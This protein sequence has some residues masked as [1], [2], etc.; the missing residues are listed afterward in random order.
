M[1]HLTRRSTLALLGGTLAAPWARR[2]HAA[3]EPVLNVYN[4]A[5]YIGETT[6]A[7]FSAQTGIKV[8]Y[9]VYS[10]T[11]EMQAKMLAGMTGYDVVNVA[12]SDMPRFLDAGLLLPLD[13]ARLASWGNLDP[14]VLRIFDT[15][16]PGN[17]YGA[18]YMWGSVGVAYNMALVRERLPDADLTSLDA[19]L[20]PENAEKLADCGISLLDSP[21]DIIPMTLAWLGL[22]GR[23]A[24]PADYPAAVAALQAIRPFVAT[25]DNN[26]YIN[27]LPNGEL[28]AVASWSG[29][30]A[31]AAARAAEAGVDIDLE[32]FV[33]TTGAPA[34]ADCLAVPADAPHP[35]NA[36]LFLEYMLQPEVIAACTNY[37]NYA[38]GNAASKPFVDPEIL[39]NPSIYPDEATVKRMWAPL[40]WT[41]EQDSALARAW[42]EV[43]TG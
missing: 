7:D 19:L 13:R 35:E 37:V 26:N 5:D 1:I 30:Y 17:A 4:W 32:Y 18:P 42:T 16:D 28:C 33:P 9:D 10:S 8:N 15:W 41:P 20:K 22:D 38:N 3:D 34:W 27:A 14:E 29:D 39:G 23:A 36:Q 21:Q 31:T 12:G 11:E 40:P 24:N 25:F 2:A 6:I 43:R